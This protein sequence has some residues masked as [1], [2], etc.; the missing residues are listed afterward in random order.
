MG[1]RGRNGRCARPFQYASQ[2]ERWHIKLCASYGLATSDPA[3]SRVS[4]LTRHATNEAQTRHSERATRLW[5]LS[6][7]KELR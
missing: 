1:I 5:I 2:N 6:I 4:L 7:G 3:E